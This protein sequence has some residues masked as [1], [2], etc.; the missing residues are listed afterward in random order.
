MSLALFERVLVPVASEADTEATCDA[1]EPYLD[2]MDEL[3]LAHVVEQT[4]GYMDHASPEALE[5]DARRFLD[6]AL[7]RL[8]GEAFTDVAVRF[9]PD[10]TE[11]LIALAEERDATAIV[12]HPRDKGL[13]SSLV[14]SSGTGELARASPIP[15]VALP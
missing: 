14:D 10:V 11:E 13:L 2:S 12:F 15:V 3:V 7:A 6:M 9:G 5:A 8:G 1:L 4:P